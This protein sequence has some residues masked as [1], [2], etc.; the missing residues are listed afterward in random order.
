M[1]Q[2]WLLGLLLPFQTWL[3][4]APIKGAVACARK[5][6]VWLVFDFVLLFFFP[7]FSFS[8]TY[9]RVHKPPTCC[10]GIMWVLLHS[11]NPTVET[12]V[13]SIT[14]PG[15]W[16]YGY[17]YSTPLSSWSDSVFLTSHILAEYWSFCGGWPILLGNV[18]PLCVAKLRMHW[19]KE[20]QMTPAH[21]AVYLAEQFSEL[22]IDFFRQRREG[23]PR[24]S[25]LRGT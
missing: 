9:F 5:K 19:M 17:K 18:I 15:N 2:M 4:E 7:L 25:L 8:K 24:L 14:L 10:R 13:L 21:R 3:E 22:Q 6:S 20:K 23:I 1:S 16:T 12:E 11:Q